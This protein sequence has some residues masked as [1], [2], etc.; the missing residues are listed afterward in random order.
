LPVLQTALEIGPKDPQT[1]LGMGQSLEALNRS[2]NTEK[3][4][5]RVLRLGSWN[6]WWNWR[7]NAGPRLLLTGCVQPDVLM[8]LTGALER[9]TSMSLEQ[10]QA[11]GI[12]IAILGQTGLDINAPE[13]KYTLRPLPGT[14]SG[15]HPCCLMLA[16]FNLWQPPGRRAPA[17]PNGGFES[18][19]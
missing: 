1:L 15:L 10:I 7:R 8:Y 13:P 19:Q 9:F 11:R 12:E 17:C 18:S 16:A 6:R 4:S 3:Y 2:Y 14:F 5:R